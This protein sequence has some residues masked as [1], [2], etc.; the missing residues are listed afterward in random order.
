VVSIVGAGD[1]P[2]DVQL[3]TVNYE[4][5]LLSFMLKVI[6]LMEVPEFRKI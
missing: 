6:E 2:L 3:K 5:V 1:L 4:L